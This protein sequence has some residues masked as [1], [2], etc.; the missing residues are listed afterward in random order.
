MKEQPHTQRT[1]D[2]RRSA[3]DTTVMLDVDR[4]FRQPDRGQYVGRAALQQND[5]ACLDR[6]ISACADG[7]TQVRLRARLG[8]IGVFSSQAVCA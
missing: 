6:H 2:S 5:V 1:R 7:D 8:C 4:R 3:F